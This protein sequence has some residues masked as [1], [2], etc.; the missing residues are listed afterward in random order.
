MTGDIG[1]VDDRG[2]LFLKGRERDEINKGGIKIF[3]ADID[4]VVEQFRA[5][6]DV[7]T[8]GFEDQFYGENVGLAVVLADCSDAALHD[9]YQWVRQH[10]A[11]HKH[12][13]R[14]YLLDEIPR[15]SRGK[16]NRDSVRDRCLS[17]TPLDLKRFAP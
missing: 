8:F 14:W 6:E 11:E 10:L 15:T 1:L 3:P 13:V 12:P 9:L 4:E 7:C 5:A 16:I 17:L 2:R